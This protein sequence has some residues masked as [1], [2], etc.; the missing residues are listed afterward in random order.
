[1]KDIYEPEFVRKLFNQM[2]ESYERMN[3]I[4][5]FGFSI[6]WR[7]QFIQKIPETNEKIKV[8]DLLS[9]LGENWSYLIKRFPNA[10]FYALD[11]SESMVEKSAVKNANHKN[12]FTILHQDLLKH[13]L[14]SDSFDIVTCAYGLKTFNEAQ[15]E[16]IAQTLNLILKEGGKFSFVEVSK[17]KSVFLNV[18]Y[19]IYLGR[20]IPVLGT[21]FLGNPQDYKMLWVYTKVFRNCEKLTEIFERNGLKVTY[22]SYFF[23]CASGVSGFKI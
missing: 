12:R 22:D 18:L 23:G 17:P 19:E 7:E 5:S 11:F 1:M 21:L 16:N 8:I 14:K 4:T 2:S 10:E 20:I 15:L 6:R 3:Y 9:G 13:Q